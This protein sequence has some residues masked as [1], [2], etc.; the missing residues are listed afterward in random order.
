MT[1]ARNSGFTLIELVLA[2]ALLAT[3]MLLMYGGLTFGL[4]SW[5]AGDVHGRRTADR[6]IAE[7]FLRREVSE[8]FPMR[9]KDPIALKL[10]FEG[11][12]NR[13][14][15]VSSRPAGLSASGLSL[16]G[17]EV[18]RDD[19][20]RTQNLVMRRAMPD[21]EARDFAPL[22]KAE[23]TILFA[24]VDSV[25]FSYFGAENDFT[26]PGWVDEWEYVGRVPQMVRIIV[27][28]S[29]GTQL[30]EIMVRM[31]VGEE[32]GCLESSFQ[33]VCRARRP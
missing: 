17:V 32:A 16:V 8:M 14:R 2:M 26:D 5:E 10:A 29:D 27:R 33:R 30:P 31:M 18:E 4:K 11:A 13:M 19:V 25:M 9:W 22:D 15:F 23:K 20:K 28:N 3:M 21:D 24:G 1:R 6:Q 7:N 12:A